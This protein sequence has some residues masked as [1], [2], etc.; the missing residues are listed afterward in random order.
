MQ[1]TSHKPQATETQ[2]G[3]YYEISKVIM[4]NCNDVT[5]YS[6]QEYLCGKESIICIKLFVAM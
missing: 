1:A 5:V 4:I 6:V 3:V 2:V